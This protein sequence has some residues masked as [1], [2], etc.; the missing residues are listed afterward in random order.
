MYLEDKSGVKY[1]AYTHEISSS[2]LK[3]TSKETKKL[4]IKYYS[5][6]GSNKTIKN[7]LFARIIL[8]YGAYSNYQNI[9]YYNNYG[10]IQIKL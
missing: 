7:I 1:Q 10:A 6:Y 2:E 5:K 3:I 9:G 4:T 8:D